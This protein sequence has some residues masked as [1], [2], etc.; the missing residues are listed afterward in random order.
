MRDVLYGLQMPDPVLSWLNL[1]MCS[2][3]YNLNVY[4]VRVCLCSAFVYVCKSVFAC[5]STSLCVFEP[6]NGLVSIFQRSP[7]GTTV[8]IGGEKGAPG[9]GVGELFPLSF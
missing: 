2:C 6:S 3:V 4:F 8:A 7:G 1:H 9:E 5:L